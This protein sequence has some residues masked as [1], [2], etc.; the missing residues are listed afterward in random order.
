MSRSVIRLPLFLILFW[1]SACSHLETSQSY[2][3]IVDASGKTPFA[4]SNL[5]AAVDAAPA[6][7]ARRY[8]ILAKAGRYYEKI[9]IN[10]SNLEIVGE[11]MDSTLI[12]FDA[13]AAEAGHY[14]DDNR[15]TP[16]SATM[17]INARDVHIANLT[18]ANTFDFPANDA[19]AKDDPSRVSASQAVALLLDTA[20]DR[21]SFD[22]VAVN[23]YQD[24]LFANGHR[25][26]FYQSHISGN[27]DFIFGRGAV[28]FDQS[29]I[30][31]R[32]RAKRFPESAIQ[33]Y[34]T[35]AS[36][37]I[38][39]DY[40]LVFLDCELRR[41]NGVPDK[42]VTLG[43]PWHPTTT[44][45]DGRYADPDAIGHAVFIR[46]YMDAHISPEGWSS[47]SG[48]ARDGTKSRVF[49]P[50]ESRFYEHRNFGPGAATNSQ[51]PQLSD[52]EAAQYTRENIFA[53]WR[54]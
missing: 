48:T 1:L 8:R 27:V 5:Q 33:G 36:T 45:D 17:S 19:K 15:G 22:S 12:Y 44:F 21:V 54:P 25:A 30:T 40:G 2:D 32:P 29:T 34:I 10:R 9:T 43:R 39:Q 38:E 53:E 37:N 3:V 31:S 47:M 26:Y 35:A 4:F 49:T 50:G 6:N 23:G 28:V 18:I 52:A 14:R 13:N 46:T 51:R 7:A 16:G 42:S 24:T 41:E 20:S 11:G